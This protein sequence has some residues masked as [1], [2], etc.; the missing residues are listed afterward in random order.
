MTVDEKK[1]KVIKAQANRINS[2]G[3]RAEN[4]IGALNQR[5]PG[6]NIGLKEE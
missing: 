5:T 1:I 4:Y 2:P 3:W 6:I